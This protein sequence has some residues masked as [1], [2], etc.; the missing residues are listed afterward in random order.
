MRGLRRS[1]LL[2]AAPVAAAVLLLAAT[3]FDLA[4]TEPFAVGVPRGRRT[5]IRLE[6]VRLTLPCAGGK[7]SIEAA[8]MEPG[9]RRLGHLALG[10]TTFLALREVRLSC[11]AGEGAFTAEAPE[12]E[13]DGERVVLAGGVVVRRED[14]RSR[15]CEELRISLGSGRVV[16]R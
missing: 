15:R 14:G 1:R 2:A 12:G 7:L 13:F 3:S 10:L 11:E 4:G 5:R 6:G 9:Y 8:V 16:F